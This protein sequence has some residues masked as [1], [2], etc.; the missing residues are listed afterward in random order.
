MNIE[1]LGDVMVAQLLAAGYVKGI[2]DLYELK[3]EQLLALERVGEKSAQALLDEIERSKAAPLARVLYGL[4]IRFVGE[5]TAQLLAA[6]F[7]SID[8][9]MAATAEELE[10]VNEVGPRVAQAIAEFFAEPR[11]RALVERLRKEGL[12]FT[13]EKR[14]T[15]ST[16]EGLTFVLTGTLPNLTRESAKEK[17]E[18]AGGRVSGSVSKKTSYVVAGEEAGS[19]LDKATSLGVTV[20]DEAGLLELLE[21][22]PVTA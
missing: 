14:L 2:A 3:K 6:H 18:S 1:G 15:T 22:G 19:K 12:T 13:A 17:I 10:A 21:R 20:V 16:L 8:A 4:G 11:N 9:L 7:G 5:R